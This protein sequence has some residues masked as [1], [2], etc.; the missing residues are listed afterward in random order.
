ME[1]IAAITPYI[2]EVPIRREVM[3]TSSLGRHDRTR[4]VLVRLLTDTG[5]EGAG[6]A[7]VTAAW[8]GE[9]AVGAAALIEQALAPVVIGRE[10]RDVSGA[11]TAMDRVAVLNP[12]AK[13]AIEM[14]MLDALGKL[15]SRPVY[16]L[17]GGQVRP[18]FIPIRFSLAA[19]AAADTAANALARVAWGHRTVKVKV[20][21]DPKAD[22][23]RVLAVRA[24]IGP[25]IALTVDA[26][27]GW[28][29][30]QAVWALQ[31]MAEADLLLAEQPVAREDLDG[32][33]AVRRCVDVPVMIDEGVFTP[34]DARRALQHEACDIIAVYP[35]K[36]GGIT[37]SVE[38][39]ELAARFGVACAVG[40]NL[41]LDVATAAMCHLTRACPNIDAENLHG[42]ILGPLYHHASPVREPLQ[43]GNGYV[44]CPDA[45]G[46][47]VEVDWDRVAAGALPVSA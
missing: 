22:V 17:L 15:E 11:L 44:T 32:M 31:A 20:G 18:A 21:L 40:S 9:T 19:L 36:N 30:R 38:I 16:D 34:L 7:T 35:G 5:V 6:E 24:A 26:N 29:V 47:G 23:D 45:P 2:L 12:F 37:R 41:E 4:V 39:V 28:T 8:S 25:D 42:D 43:F 13:S 33:A 27:G 1:R 10:L 3:I 46:L 14:A